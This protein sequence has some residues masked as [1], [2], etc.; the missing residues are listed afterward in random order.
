MTDATITLAYSL[1]RV[2]CDEQCQK[3]WGVD[4]RP[5]VQ[6]SDDQ[7]DFAFLADGELGEA[8]ADPG[9]YEGGDA[10]PSSSQQFP[11]KWCVRQCERC[12]IT[13]LG[14]PETPLVLPDFSQRV[15]NMPSRHP[16]AATSV[17]ESVQ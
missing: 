2:A 16:E 10:K 1:A 9:T 6:L 3:A 7:N 5:R 12:A 4:L 13:P 17:G 11:N 14:S 15:Y 8:P